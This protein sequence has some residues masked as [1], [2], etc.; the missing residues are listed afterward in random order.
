MKTKEKTIDATGF[1][2]VI[3]LMFGT[4]LKGNDVVNLKLGKSYPGHRHLISVSLTLKDGRKSRT[5][6]FVK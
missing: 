1:V 3:D 6:K 2:E 4:P 5:I